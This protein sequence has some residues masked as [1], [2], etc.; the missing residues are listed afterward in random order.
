MSGKDD[1]CSASIRVA[2][3]M[4]LLRTPLD[5]IELYP[6]KYFFAEKREGGED[7]RGQIETKRQKKTETERDAETERQAARQTERRIRE[8]DRD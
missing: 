4:D 2:L 1:G 8:R 3:F 7:K 5:I 6:P